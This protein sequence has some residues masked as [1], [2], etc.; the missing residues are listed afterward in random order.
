MSFASTFDH[1]DRRVRDAADR[2][3]LQ[4]RAVVPRHVVPVPGLLEER[5][6]VSLV[7]VGDVP[8]P[9]GELGL[10][11]HRLVVQLHPGTIQ[12]PDIGM[13]GSGGRLPS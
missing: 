8:P 6:L 13:R 12:E 1:D 2:A 4:V 9:V 10:R 3:E 7:G 5:A 11:H